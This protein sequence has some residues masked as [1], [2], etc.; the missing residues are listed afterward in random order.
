MVAEFIGGLV[1]GSLA[2]LADAGHMLSD[3]VLL[4]LALAAIWIARRPRTAKHT[5]DHSTIQIEDC[6][7]PSR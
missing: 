5:I 1:S 7:P 4:G 2:L 6:D 3:A